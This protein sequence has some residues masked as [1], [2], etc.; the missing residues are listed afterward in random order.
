M[1]YDISITKHCAHYNHTE[2]LYS[3][4]YTF[5]VAKMYQLAFNN[6]R[7]IKILNNLS[8]KT[9]SVFLSKAIDYMYSNATELT[10]LNPPNKWGNYEDAKDVLANLHSNCIK[11]STDDYIV[12]IGW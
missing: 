1:S 7:G 5:N 8:T 11:Y 3:D 2:I 9:A 6:E 10:K 12:E 4:N